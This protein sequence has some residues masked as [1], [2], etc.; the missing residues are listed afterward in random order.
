[1]KEVKTK[2]VITTRDVYIREIENVANNRFLNS[3]EKKIKI[4]YLKTHLDKLK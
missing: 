3:I 2:E 1:M 4:E